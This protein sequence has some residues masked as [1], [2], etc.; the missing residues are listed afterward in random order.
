VEAL[1]ADPAA[2]EAVFDPRGDPLLH[3]S[4]FLVFALAVHQTAA[5]LEAAA[6]VPERVRIAAGTDSG[7]H[8]VGQRRQR[9]AGNVH[10]ATRAEQD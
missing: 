5:E 7:L 10:W 4:P 3:A 8:R 1:L 6:F 2:Y 9:R